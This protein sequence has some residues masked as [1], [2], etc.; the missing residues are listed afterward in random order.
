MRIAV[1]TGASGRLGGALVSAFSSEH[2]EVTGTS[3]SG[4]GTHTVLDPAILDQCREFWKTVD[5]TAD[6][7][8]VNNAGNYYEGP[9]VEQ[10]DDAAVESVRACYL[11][12]VHM[13][14]TLMEKFESARIINLVSDSALSPHAGNSTYGAAKA[15]SAHF[16][17][18]LQEEVTSADHQITNVFPGS[19]APDANT[20]EGHMNP[21]ELAAFVVSLAN[22]GSSIYVKDITIEP[23]R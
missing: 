22:G 2:W 15:A 7:C 19:I 13:T 5:R 3:R 17:G 11:T 1:I 14:K 12:A 9:F 21:H 23:T 18:A 16:F 10:P 4:A 8:L 6:V 20:L